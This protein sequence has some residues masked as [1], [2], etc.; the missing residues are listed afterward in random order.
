[1]SEITVRAV[2]PGQADGAAPPEG[3]AIVRPLVHVRAVRARYLQRLA[4]PAG[5]AASRAAR[6]WAWALGETGH[7]PVT[8]RLTGT[9]PSRDEI[10]A[11]ITEADQRRL[12]G[13]REGR[14]DAAATVLRWLLGT[15]DHVPVR[16]TNPGELVGGFGDI[17]RSPEQMADLVVLARAA[18]QAAAA[19]SLDVG[20]APGERE[21]A[22]QEADYLDGTLMTLAWVYGER[23]ETPVSHAQAE[24]TS[25]TLKRERLHA[26]D[27]IQ[28]GADQPA[29]GRPSRFY[30]EGAQST[31][32]WLLGDSTVPPYPFAESSDNQ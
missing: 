29:A 7:A 24:L 25:R 32:S 14:A 1:M 31:I 2:D 15:D 13:T 4:D 5:A 8:D 3:T 18:Q 9:P 26:E 20:A 27:A 11:E 21:H 22:R 30:G 16:C 28:Q 23:P 10:E 17:V 6:A 12:H 19:R